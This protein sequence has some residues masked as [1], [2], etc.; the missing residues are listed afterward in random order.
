MPQFAAN[1][2]MLF[3]ELPFMERFAAARAAGFDAVE[4]LFPYPYAKEELAERCK[5]TACSRC[6]T[7]CPPATGTRANAASPATPSRVDEFRAG[8]AQAIDYATALRLPAV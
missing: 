1:L 8:V 6:C 4:Y 7:T 3:T 2:S 5:P